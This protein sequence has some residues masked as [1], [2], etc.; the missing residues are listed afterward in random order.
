M[1][2]LANNLITEE[3]GEKALD[4]YQ[5]KVLGDRIKNNARDINRLI[6]YGDANVVPTE[7]IWFTFDK[8]NRTITGFAS[9]IADVIIP[10]EI[11]VHEEFT[12]GTSDIYY[13]VTVI[14]SGCFNENIF[15]ERVILPNTIETISLAAFYG[16][17]NLT[18]ITIPDSVTF[19]A[20]NAFSGCDNVVI[21]CN[22]GSYAETYAIENGIAY[23]S[24]AV[25]VDNEYDPNSTNPQS[26]KAVAEALESVIKVP[27]QEVS[28]TW[29]ILCYP[30]EGVNRMAIDASAY[31]DDG[32]MVEFVLPPAPDE[33]YEEYG[34]AHFHQ[35][36]IQIDVRVDISVSWGTSTFFN[37]EIPDIGIGKYDFIFEW[38]GENWCAGAIEK[39]V[40]VS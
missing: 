19:I 33:G 32:N 12:W 28:Q 11:W 7:S 14:G 8:A 25:Y 2:E 4:A 13:P 23:K 16:C 10:Y 20:E 30:N 29:G 15:V 9:N 1:P 6:Y 17:P 26:G 38:D 18:S 34:E 22:A 31:F 5:G 40:V 21:Y 39:G 36:L 35:I 3:P 27:V 24:K 37:G